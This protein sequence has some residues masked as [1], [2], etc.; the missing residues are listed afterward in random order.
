MSS[1]NT[2]RPISTEDTDM[3]YTFYH[4]KHYSKFLTPEPEDIIHFHYNTS[5]HF[6]RSGLFLYTDWCA[7]A[8]MAP[9][10]WSS[11]VAVK[12]PHIK[13]SSRAVTQYHE[14]SF[15]DVVVCTYRQKGCNAL[16]P[17]LVWPCA[18]RCHVSTNSGWNIFLFGYDQFPFRFSFS[19]FKL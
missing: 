6:C 10:T 1:S 19:A 12:N 5:V 18:G 16:L 8:F 14:G 7:F 4:L 9:Y 2:D 13:L 15:E 17:A 3:M 11:K